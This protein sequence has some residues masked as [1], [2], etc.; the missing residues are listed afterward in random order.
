M[1][2][3]LSSASA[4]SAA[5]QLRELQERIHLLQGRRNREATYAVLPA[6]SPLLPYGLRAGAVYSLEAPLSVAMA[7]LAAP[8]AEGHWCGVAGIPDFGAEAAAGFGI[9]LERTVLVPDPGERWL[10]TVSALADVLPLLLVRPPALASGGEASR[11][12]SRLR[13]RG[14]TLLILG[15]WPQAEGVLSVEGSRWNGLG[16]GHGH[17]RSHRVDLVWSQRGKRRTTIVDLAALHADSTQPGEA[18]LSGARP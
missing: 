12:S 6:F 3:P 9:S 5:E 18:R 4:A 17:L 13:E 16:D 14:C 7:L 8:S 15:S 10:V 11:L 2:L 1:S